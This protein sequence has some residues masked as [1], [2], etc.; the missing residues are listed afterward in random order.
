MQMNLLTELGRPARPVVEWE[1]GNE[2]SFSF[3]KTARDEYTKEP[4]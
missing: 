2:S 4:Q 1:N 3:Q